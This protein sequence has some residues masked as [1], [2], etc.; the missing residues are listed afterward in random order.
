MKTKE[1]IKC[2][3]EIVETHEMSNS[4]DSP[5]Q[6][7]ITMWR[8]YFLKKEMKPFSDVRK[9]FVRQVF[10]TTPTETMICQDPKSYLQTIEKESETN[11][12]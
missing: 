4:P 6:K 5:I 7:E 12:K 2:L 1:L 9:E 3:R 8:E 11:C 10:M